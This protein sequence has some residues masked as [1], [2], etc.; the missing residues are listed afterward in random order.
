ML[1]TKRSSILLLAVLGMIPGCGRPASDTE[2]FQAAWA[3]DAQTVRELVLAQPALLTAKM[4]WRSLLHVALMTGQYD[5]AKFLLEKE[6][7][8]CDVPDAHGVRPI[9]LAGS[10]DLARRLLALGASPN[11]RDDQGETPLH[12]A[13][14]IEVVNVLLEA[15]ADPHAE[16]IFGN[17]PLVCVAPSGRPDVVGRLLE[18][19]T[20]MESVDRAL[21]AAALAGFSER[22]FAAAHN[23]LEQPMSEGRKKWMDGLQAVAEMLV[24]RRQGLKGKS[25]VW[26]MPRS[27]GAYRMVAGLRLDQEAIYRA[28][29][30]SED[31]E[32][33]VIVRRVHGT[34]FGIV[35][36]VLVFGPDM[37][38][39]RCGRANAPDES[40][41]YAL[42]EVRA[43][44]PKTPAPMLDQWLLTL[45][46]WNSGWG[47]D[48]R[49]P[50]VVPS[51]Q[52]DSRRDANDLVGAFVAWLGHEPLAES[53]VDAIEGN[54]EVRWA[55]ASDS[56]L[57]P[58]VSG[59]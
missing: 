13:T 15:G 24:V 26:S 44:G 31:G 52:A 53:H 48:E 37:R 5:L 11:A 54:V 20:D 14:S 34:L 16:D 23:A 36:D 51:A 49:L 22:Y 43:T 57:A 21:V 50:C 2:V 38:V 12:D 25:T 19:G 17:T 47:L 32:R 59:R 3:E 45:V 10:A 41:P 1:Q 42:V 35:Y 4:D 55:E 29:W 7:G 40:V 46:T 39:L 9:H 28:V 30:K 8:L 6:K 27:R 58:P 18:E 33:L 56:L